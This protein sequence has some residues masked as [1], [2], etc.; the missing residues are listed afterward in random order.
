MN[1][2]LRKRFVNNQIEQGKWFQNKMNFKGLNETWLTPKPNNLNNQPFWKII[3]LLLL[4][5]IDLILG[6]YCASKSYLKFYDLLL[7]M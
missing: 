7:I 3:V 5:L 2:P 6:V 1:L 4:L